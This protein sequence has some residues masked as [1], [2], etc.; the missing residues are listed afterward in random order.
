MEP[1]LSKRDLKKRII[2]EG[3]IKIFDL[4]TSDIIDIPAVQRSLVWKPSQVELLWDS[5]LRGFPIGALILSERDSG[6]SLMD[7][8][9][10]FNAICLGFHN[11]SA[12]KSKLWIDICPI[13]EKKS[14]RKFLVKVTTLSHPWGYK[15]DDVCTAF[16]THEKRCAMET[17]GY[18]G[19][20]LFQTKISLDDTWPIQAKCPIP[21]HILLRNSIL[22]TSEEFASACLNDIKQENKTYQDVIASSGIDVMQSL[23]AF[24][25]PAKMARTQYYLPFSLLDQFVIENEQEN[26][27]DTPETTDIEILFQRITTGGTR[28]TQ[29]EL[30]YSAIKVYWPEIK[31]ICESTENK[32]IPAHQLANMVFRLYK[33]IHSEKHEWV[34][35]DLSLSEI[36]KLS[37]S[38]YQRINRL[39]GHLPVLVDRVNSWFT[40]GK[41]GM[42]PILKTAIAKQSPDVYLLSLWLATEEHELSGD[43]IRA[44]ALL[45]KW[46]TSDCASVAASI[47][48]TCKIEGISQSSIIKGIYGSRYSRGS[49][50]TW[51]YP[52]KDIQLMLEGESF[53]KDWHHGR[54]FGKKLYDLWSLIHQNPWELPDLLLY[55]E[56]EYM[57]QRFPYYDP[58]QRD[59]WEKVNRPWD[60]DHIIPHDWIFNRK[61]GDWRH[62][63]KQWLNV[64]GNMAAIPFERNRAKGNR[65]NWDY[66]K[67]HESD[68]LVSSELHCSQ[69]N[70]DIVTSRSQAIKFAEFTIERTLRIYNEAYKALAP[71]VESK[72]IT[73]YPVQIQER[74]SRMLS[75]MEVI[76]QD[77]NLAFVP[78]YCDNDT[79]FT[80]FIEYPDEWAYHWIG[81]VK[82]IDKEID[83]VVSMNDIANY[84]V[85]FRISSNMQH[86]NQSSDKIAKQLMSMFPDM[87]EGDAAG[88]W[89]AYC[90]YRINDVSLQ[91]LAA[92]LD[93][94]YRTVLQI[95]KAVNDTENT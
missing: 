2:E 56:R 11:E 41:L 80:Y 17:F 47:Y 78:S 26:R 3:H 29:S 69:F 89:Y 23:K 65:E 39:F 12:N 92:K 93:G 14:T 37:K 88:H 90:C 27:Q 64:I 53:K 86:K 61:T 84:K 15:N 81:L 55:A 31:S 24:Y 13:F 57:G 77:S 40:E 59:M 76:K 54:L 36:R 85:G 67:K 25:E 94:V 38:E 66:Y 95:Y 70:S 82:N 46:H 87:E 7:G 74:K 30:N 83:L 22:S 51:P 1:N 8:Q 72:E 33:L 52:T 35:K 79:G 48:S 73:T 43:F 49:R 5:I 44:M 16:N 42:P 4:A 45:L 91:D 28:I 20:T 75:L 34:R 32:C 60:Y 63:C 71:L 9:Q 19:K 68:L 6:F 18:T 50:I 10:R 21:L 62:F 58:A